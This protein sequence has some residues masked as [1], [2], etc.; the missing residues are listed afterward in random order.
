MDGDLLRFLLAPGGVLSGDSLSA[1][2]VLSDEEDAGDRELRD[3]EA[4]GCSI[5]VLAPDG[6]LDEEAE[7]SSIAEGSM[8]STRILT[9]LRTVKIDVAILNYQSW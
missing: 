6:F 5:N 8:L 4:E 7:G 2:G 9:V 3:R 1:G